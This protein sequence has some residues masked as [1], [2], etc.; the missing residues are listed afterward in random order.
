APALPSPS[1]WR[2]LQ[3]DPSFMEITDLWTRARV[4]VTGI[5]SP[6]ARRESLTSVVPRE[7]T[8]LRGA[9][10]DLC[11]HFFD[12]D[13]KE[14]LYP[15]SDRLVRPSVEQLRAIPTSIAL[16]AGGEKVSSIRAGARTGLF[17]TLITD[18]L[19]AEAVLAQADG[20]R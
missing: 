5:G 3:A 1:L 8:G 19:T 4:L 11:L 16:A 14:V 9:V 17:T 18:A 6:Y 7:D 2:S 10:G 15:G 20:E 12:A 13:G